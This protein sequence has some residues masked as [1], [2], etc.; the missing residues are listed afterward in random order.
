M[1]MLEGKLFFVAP[2]AR[3]IPFLNIVCRSGQTLR[4]E[5]SSS[6]NKTRFSYAKRV[7]FERGWT[8]IFCGMSWLFR[9][10][11]AEQ[12]RVPGVPV[13]TKMRGASW[14]QDK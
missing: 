2:K 14:I 11:L 12:K 8:V 6:R 5:H 1:G 10:C 7:R 9:S 13:G 3:D 4:N